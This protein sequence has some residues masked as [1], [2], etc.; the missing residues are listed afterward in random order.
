MRG[1]AIAVLVVGGLFTA[2]FLAVKPSFKTPAAT[3]AASTL[4]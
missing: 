2:V 1:T 3:S 4:L